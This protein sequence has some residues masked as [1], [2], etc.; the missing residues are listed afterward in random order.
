MP[1]I[2]SSALPI[3]IGI[4]DTAESNTR[5]AMSTTISSGRP[6]IILATIRRFNVLYH[7]SLA[8]DLKKMEENNPEK[9]E[10]T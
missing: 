5:T 2:A 7:S 6:P 4:L 10:G 9:K 1:Y 3:A 8:W